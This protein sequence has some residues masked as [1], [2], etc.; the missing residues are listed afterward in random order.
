MNKKNAV[1]VRDI[2]KR[3][4]YTRSKNNSLKRAITQAFKKKDK[5]VEDFYALD[6]I[7][8]DVEKGDFFGILGRN[9]SGK[10]TLLKIISEIYKP[11]S[12][13][14]KHRGKLVSFIELGVGFKA[15]LT[16][17]ENVYL[18]GALLGFSR[19]EVDSMYDDIVEFAELEKFMDQQLKNYSSGMQVRLAF[20]VAI[21]SHADVLILDEVL[22]VGD[23]AFQR[24]C[25]EYFQSLKEDKKTVILVTHSMSA[26]K[27]YCNKAIL[28]EGGKIV[29]SG[30]ADKVAD[31]YTRLFIENKEGNSETRDNNRYGEGGASIGKISVSPNTDM[32]D[33]YISIK[34]ETINSSNIA[35]GIDIVDSNRRLIGGFESSTI[36]DDNLYT[37]V[38]GKIYDF[39][40]QIENIFG[41]RDY[42]VNISLKESDNSR[43]Y[44]FW[45]YA[46]MFTNINKKDYNN[47]FPVVLR[48]KQLNDSSKKR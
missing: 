25:N 21:R 29:H 26:V 45:R 16:G 19:S 48:A 27:N 35:L 9:G 42:G 14:V 37:V 8:F 17:K 3:F 23:A 36:Q 31:E 46:T 43:V 33:L 2:H 12:G 40:Y 13:Q 18:N 5:G 11:T 30:A 47:Y 7:S 38:P 32:I 10:S 41:S 24:K 20:S 15:E 4:L 44:D 34:S 28:I 39:H 22:A 1:E 6:G